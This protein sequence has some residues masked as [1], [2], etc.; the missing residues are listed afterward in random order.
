MCR[1]GSKS[2]EKHIRRSRRFSLL[3]VCG[4]PVGGIEVCVPYSRGYYARTAVEVQDGLSEGSQSLE[5]LYASHKDRFLDRIIYV[6][7]NEHSHDQIKKGNNQ[8]RVRIRT[9]SVFTQ[10]RV[11]V[12][13]T[14]NIHAGITSRKHSQRATRLA[15][16]KWYP[17]LRETVPDTTVNV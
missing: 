4:G 5:E 2:T 7:P 12:G 11:H 17:F 14:H 3:A 1:H 9:R 10:K 6:L 16:K 13:I 8:K 15:E